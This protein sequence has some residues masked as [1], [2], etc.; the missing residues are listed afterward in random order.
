MKKEPAAPARVRVKI[1]GLKRPAYA[2]DA[3]RAGADA[4]GVVFAESPSRVTLEEARA[5]A[6]AARDEAAKA[7]RTIET[8]G[9]FVNEEAGRIIELAREVPLDV[10]QLHGDETLDFARS[11][12]DLRLV[13]AVRVR[14]SGALEEIA[15]FA[16]S[17]AFEAVLLDSFDERARAGRVGAPDS[18]PG[19]PARGSYLP[20]AEAPGGAPMRRGGTG[21]TF[22]W[23]VAREAAERARVVLAGG[24]SPDNV[25]EAVRRVR[26]WMV[27]ASSG[28]ESAPGEKDAALVERFVSE[29]TSA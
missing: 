20:G 3:V 24:L 1:C 4:V 10:A 13:R 14:D 18:I 15:R 25:A 22:D 28:V 5:V 12:G 8:W 19:P 17:G 27:D 29:A 2:R 26:P 21:R 23:G 11:L 16:S 7:G 9:V 6:A